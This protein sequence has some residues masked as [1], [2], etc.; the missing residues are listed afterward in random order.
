MVTG[1]LANVI[2]ERAFLEARERYATRWAWEWR[3]ATAA[4]RALRTVQARHSELDLHGTIKI[5]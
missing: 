2:L 4:A 5:R 1:V 3:N